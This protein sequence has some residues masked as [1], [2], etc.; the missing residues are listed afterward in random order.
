VALLAINR[1]CEQLNYMVLHAYKFYRSI[2][3]RALNELHQLYQL[4]L[5]SDVEEKLPFVNEQLQS[6]T[7]FKEYYCQILL[8]S[9]SNPYGLNSGEVLDAYHMMAQLTAIVEVSPLPMGAKVVAG[10]FYINCLSDRAPMPSVLPT[11]ANQ[12]QPPALVLNTKPALIVVD[13]LFQQAKNTDGTATVIDITLLKKLIPYLNTSY[14]RKQ[15]RVPVTGNKNAY[16]AIGLASV[17]QCLSD[18]D[19][20]SDDVLTLLNQAWGILN[21]NSA[22]YLVERHGVI[23]TQPMAIGNLLSIFEANTAGKKPLMKLAFIRWLKTD[24]HGKTKLGLEIIEGEPIAVHYNLQDNEKSEP[25]ILMPEISRINSPASLITK[26]GIFDQGRILQIKPKNKR[27]Q[28]N[29][30]V[31]S[32]VDKSDNFERFTF[33]DEL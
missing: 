11:I 20:V 30:T 16:L 17:H 31:K 33:N 5:T 3:V 23:E 32:L 21:K 22:G 12:A 26:V 14:E 9:I 8:V 15:A 2:P 4:T 29:V 28:F 19:G 18:V 25:A 10:H 6:D 27:F 13:S 7:S 1:A 24:H